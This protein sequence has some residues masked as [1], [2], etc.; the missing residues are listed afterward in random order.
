[1]IKEAVALGSGNLGGLPGE[2]SHLEN[3]WSWG[4][5]G[6]TQPVFLQVWFRQMVCVQ[7]SK[8]MN[9]WDQ[10]VCTEVGGQ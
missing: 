7:S 5:W 3:G 2:G 6:E 9:Q 4:W 1:M 10:A 8:E